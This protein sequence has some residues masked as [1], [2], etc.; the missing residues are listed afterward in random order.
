VSEEVRSVCQSSNS[1]AI[2]C[3]KRSPLSSPETELSP[4]RKPVPSIFWPM[5][6]EVALVIPKWD[7]PM[8][9]DG[10]QP[11]PNLVT[12]ELPVIPEFLGTIHGT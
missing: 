5:P 11:L 10:R 2:V 7:S 4:L 9:L 8:I 12:S 1:V 6:G 3:A